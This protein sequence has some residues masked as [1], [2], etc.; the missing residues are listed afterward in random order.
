MANA[1]RATLFFLLALALTACNKP[2]D[3]PQPGTTGAKAGA[4]KTGETGKAEAAQKKGDAPAEAPAAT[5]PI[6]NVNGVAIDREEFDAKYAK[7][8]KAFT[9]RKKDIPAG[10]AK[11]YRE[12][13]LK[14]LIDKELLRQKIAEAGVTVGDEALAKE[15]EDYK[16]MFR[17]EENFQRYLKS[18]SITLEQIQANISHNLAVQELLA[19]QGDLAVTDA[20]VTEYYEK[21]QSRYEIKEQIRASHILFKVA[22]KDDKDEDAAAKKKADGVYKDAAKKGADFAALAKKHSEGPTAS[23]GGDLSY[24]NRGRMVPEFEKVAF[25]MKV[26]DVSKPVKTQFGWHVIKVT[27]RKE[28]RKRPF[29]EVK[30]SISKLLVN[31]KSRKAKAALLKELKDTAKVESFLPKEPEPDPSEEAEKA[32]ADKKGPAVKLAPASEP[33]SSP[34]AVAAPAPGT[35]EKKAP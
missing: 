19:K 18:S 1:T 7:M 22:K 23:R 16:K 8:T 2:T 31:K 34:G 17:T 27:D 32:K 30:E 24:F 10:L 21:N 13:I 14:Q 33:G 15:L 35:D 26:G 4:A 20:E 28:G 3:T 9:T 12:S 25:T 29:D 11:R 6:A 5:G